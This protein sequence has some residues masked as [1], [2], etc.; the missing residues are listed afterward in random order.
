MAI[1][2]VSSSGNT[3]GSSAASSVTV[4]APA[5]IATGNLLIAV[6]FANDD[7]T[8]AIF[9]APT[10]WAPAGV[11]STGTPSGDTFITDMAVFTKFA[12]ASEPTNYTF[13]F[14]NST[15]LIVGILQYSGVPS[16]APLYGSAYTPFYQVTSA[17]AP[18]LTSWTSG[19]FLI[20]AWQNFGA[21]IS[22]NPTG[23]T[24]R[25]AVGV[26]GYQNLVLYDLSVNSGLTP[27]ETA[28]FSTS[29]TGSAISLLITPTIVDSTIV[30][31]I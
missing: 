12:T 1:A 25:L 5:S 22:T 8:S 16:S 2:Y 7:S 24:Q 11:P 30:T 9:S 29:C 28:S 6:C 13:A 31:V 19:E 21:T 14:T 27:L 18:V 17:T 23:M 20:C 3:T 4:T 10:G 15:N 26:N